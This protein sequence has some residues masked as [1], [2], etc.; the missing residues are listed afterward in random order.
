MI[1]LRRL[2]SHISIAEIMRSI[3]LPLETV[4]H[5]LRFKMVLILILYKYKTMV[6]KNLTSPGVPKLIG[7]LPLEPI[8]AMMEMNKIMNA[9]NN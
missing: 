1:I 8:T 4:G 9:A 3:F 6:F 7:R 5:L 2:K